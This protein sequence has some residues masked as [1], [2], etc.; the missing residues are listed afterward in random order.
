MVEN[1]VK[2][3]GT[4]GCLWPLLFY[5]RSCKI[6]WKTSSNLSVQWTNLCSSY[7]I[8]EFF[9]KTI[10]TLCQ[11][12]HNCQ[13]GFKSQQHSLPAPTCESQRKLE[14]T[15]SSKPGLSHTG[16][17]QFS[18][19]HQILHHLAIQDMMHNPFQSIG[20]STLAQRASL[21]VSMRVSLSLE[22]MFNTKH[23]MKKFPVALMEL[24]QI[25]LD[26]FLLLGLKGAV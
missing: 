10:I 5:L 19:H 1:P 20:W 25:Y 26:Q 9:F 22:W 8:H 3:Q 21:G 17:V 11:C 18:L 4:R 14:S 2:F 6:V 12:H 16:P 13:I 7:H 23:N 15:T 24:S